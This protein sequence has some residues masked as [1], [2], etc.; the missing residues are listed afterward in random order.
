MKINYLEVSGYKR[1]MLNNIKSFTITPKEMYQLII[2]TNGSGKSS[3]IKELTPLPADASNYSK[4]GYKT[5]SVTHHGVNYFLHSSGSKHSFLNEN[6]NEEL[7]PGHTITVQ[8]ELVKQIFGI[9]P[10]SH[11]LMIGAETFHD[12]SPTRRREWFSKLSPFNYDYAFKVYNKL[13]ETHR[14]ISGTLKRSKARLVTESAKLINA[15]EE[16]KLRKDVELTVKELNLLIEQSAPVERPLAHIREDLDDSMGKLTALSNKLIR[17]RLTSSYGTH[18]YGVNETKKE[19]RDEW[20][21][22]IKPG[23]TSIEEIDEVIDKTRHEITA[24]ETLINTVS[25]E[26]NKLLETASIL[27]RTGNEGVSVIQGKI[28]NANNDKID[29]LFKRK[30]CLEV[31]DPENA[32]KALSSIHDD[33]T[34]ILST[35]KE[36]ADRRYSQVKM[37][38]A[39]RLQ[40]VLRDTKR[41]LV[42]QLERLIVNKEHMEAHKTTSKVECPKCNHSWALNYSE[43]R[44]QE[45]LSLVAKKEQEVKDVEIKIKEVDDKIVELDNYS[46]LFKEYVRYTK[47]WP[48]LNSLWDYL[49]TNELISTAPIKALNTTNIFLHDLEFDVLAIAKDKELRELRELL[50]SAEAVGDANLNDC[51]DKIVKCETVLSQLTTELMQLKTSLNKHISYKNQLTEAFSIHAEIDSLMKNSRL[52]NDSLIENIRRNILNHCVR[53]LQTSLAIKQEALTAALMQNNLIADLQKQIDILTIEEEASKLLVKELSPTDGLIAEGL[54]G[55]VNTFVNQMNLVI[56]KIW[57]YPLKVLN[58]KVEDESSFQLDYK[59]PLMVSRSDNVVDDVKEGSTGMREI[60]NLAF[61]VVAMKYLGLADSILVLDEFASSFDKEH[62]VSAMNA[63]KTI[64]DQNSFTQLF[65]VSHYSE[66]YSAFTNAEVC[67]LCP[68]NVVT[69]GVNNRHVSIS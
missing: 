27:T 46:I 51:Q 30:L 10:D 68:K 43:E 28:N 52:L 29:I 33:L 42:S 7:N 8:K 1:F 5:I 17:M 14:D 3:L 32:L 44:Y 64:M 66:A 18:P 69:P 34:N 12:M 47:N 50:K 61:K 41:T 57:S 21:Q 4:G 2:G 49:A 63:I 9:T 16:S 11:N 24:K 53:Q 25:D 54:M 65:M 39:N 36:N 20:Y 6:T 19:E 62:R 58:C 48:L 35:I 23:F 59:F 67:V 40:F 60:V 13:K 22:V 55:F 45:I 15:E 56:R 37:E 31:T 38:E 26:H